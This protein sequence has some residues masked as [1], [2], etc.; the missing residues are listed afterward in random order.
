MGMRGL[1]AQSH[2]PQTQ[3]DGGQSQEDTMAQ[4][5]GW[6]QVLDEQTNAE[7]ARAHLMITRVLPNGTEWEGELLS[8]Q[9]VQ[10]DTIPSGRY[11]LRF[12]SGGQVCCAEIDGASEPP[13][14]RG[15]ELPAVLR[16]LH[17]SD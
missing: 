9:A 13:F 10:A 3:V 17:S 8:V 11:A 7:V 1:L 6:V 14:V 2:P 15:R 16:E 4:D 5:S 12:E